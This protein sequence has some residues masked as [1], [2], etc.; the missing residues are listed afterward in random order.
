MEEEGEAKEEVERWKKRDVDPQRA[1]AW[2]F[3]HAT[4][5]QWL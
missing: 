5:G 2:F 3:F 1:G 4:C